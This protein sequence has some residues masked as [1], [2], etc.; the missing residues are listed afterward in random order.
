MNKMEI[1]N[2]EKEVK[3]MREECEKA[4]EKIYDALINDCEYYLDR[5]SFDELWQE[6]VLDREVVLAV[7]SDSNG[8]VLGDATLTDCLLC[9]IKKAGYTHGF[10]MDMQGF[11]YYIPVVQQ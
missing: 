5:E 6:A 8:N 11:F 10:S 1:K 9:A 3:K 2:K 7:S 4:L